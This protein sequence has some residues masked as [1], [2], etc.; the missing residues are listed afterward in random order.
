[1]YVENGT[2]PPVQSSP[3]PWTGLMDWTGMFSLPVRNPRVSA[4]THYLILLFSSFFCFYCNTY[5]NHGT[6]PG[7]VVSTRQRPWSGYSRR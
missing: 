2:S 6:R 5:I 7:P 4:G 3:S 1:M